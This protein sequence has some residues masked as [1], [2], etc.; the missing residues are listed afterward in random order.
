MMQKKDVA[1]DLFAIYTSALV[2]CFFSS[3]AYVLPGLFD[4]FTFEKPLYVLETAPPLH[5]Q[6]ADIFSHCV[7]CLFVLLTGSFTEQKH[8]ILISSNLLIFFFYVS[9]FGIKV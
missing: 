9:D 8:L 7:A 3:F 2:N 4:F 5:T 1:M 6:F